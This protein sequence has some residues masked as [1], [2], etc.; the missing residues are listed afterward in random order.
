[1]TTKECRKILESMGFKF[2][3]W[4]TFQKHDI[5]AC[6]T[7]NQYGLCVKFSHDRLPYRTEYKLQ[8]R[9]PK[10]INCEEARS[11]L[12]YCYR[13]VIDKYVVNCNNNIKTLFGEMSSIIE[14]IENIIEG[15]IFKENPSREIQES[16]NLLVLCERIEKYRKE[17]NV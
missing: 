17:L 7:A 5:S 10:E 14:E 12:I 4:Y 2:I 16:I 8:W 9:N 6:M 15:N 1:M 3:R 13:R 11:D